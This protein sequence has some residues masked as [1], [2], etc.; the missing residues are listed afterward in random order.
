MAVDRND[1]SPSS[2]ASSVKSSVSLSSAAGSSFGL[3]G[4]RASIGR[5]SSKSSGSMRLGRFVRCSGA[6]RCSAGLTNHLTAYDYLYAVTLRGYITRVL[7]RV[8]RVYRLIC[9]VVR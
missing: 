1:S 8:P 2:S 7:Q 6:F 3:S 5:I 9:E 4:G